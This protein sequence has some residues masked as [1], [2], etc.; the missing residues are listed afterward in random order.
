MFMYTDNHTD[1]E[2][3]VA[4]VYIIY[5][6]MFNITCTYMKTLW[7]VYGIFLSL[8]KVCIVIYSETPQ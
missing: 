8:L 5:M 2:T 3:N 7:Y 6:F 4:Q 1:A